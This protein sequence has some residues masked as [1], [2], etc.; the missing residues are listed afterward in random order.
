MGAPGM[1]SAVD[2]RE[3][4]GSLHHH[5][6]LPAMPVHLP[7]PVPE[8]QP[9]ASTARVLQPSP[10]LLLANAASG[11][12]CIRPLLDLL[13][14]RHY[15]RLNGTRKRALDRVLQQPGLFPG[16][17]H[18]PSSPLGHSG[19]Q[20]PPSRG[21]GAPD[22]VPLPPAGSGQHLE[23]VSS[24]ADADLG[25]GTAERLHA[26]ADPRAPVSLTLHSG[27]RLLSCHLLPHWRGSLAV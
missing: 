12:H 2:R 5:S 9:A 26:T 22:M 13:H 8:R 23:E 16:G 18:P 17:G 11:H 24:H 27:Y 3:A 14:L 15:G 1:P 20:G 6:G 7:H 10:D 4:A 19:P 25:G 21:P